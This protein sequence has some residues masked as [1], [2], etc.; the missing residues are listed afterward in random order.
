MQTVD[1]KEK[2]LDSKPWRG[3]FALNQGA[4]LAGPNVLSSSVS[5]PLTYRSAG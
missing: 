3:R 2:Q 5:F 1:L 4:L